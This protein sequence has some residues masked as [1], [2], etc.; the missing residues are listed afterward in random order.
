M[1]TP[2]ANRERINDIELIMTN[3]AY[4][5]IMKETYDE[6]IKNS[7][8][9]T[10]IKMC[11]IHN[12]VKNHLQKH[13]DNDLLDSSLD[14]DEFEVIEIMTTWVCHMVRSEISYSTVKI[15]NEES[16]NDDDIITKQPRGFG[17]A[18][19]IQLTNMFASDSD[20]IVQFHVNV[21]GCERINNN[22]GYYY[23]N[24]LNVDKIIISNND[25]STLIQFAC[26]L[27]V[28]Y[29]SSVLCLGPYINKLHGLISRIIYIN[30][31]GEYKYDFAFEL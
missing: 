26:P 16:D 15:D 3:K 5:Q 23:V 21:F 27:V 29:S 22:E 2:I 31:F 20:Y 28:D 12:M 25:D 24:H 6:I 18:C 30:W 10:F 14:E 19:L 8:H 1:F 9:N 4:I 17:M 13:H 11:D 7:T